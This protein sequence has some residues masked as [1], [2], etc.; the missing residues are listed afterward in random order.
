MLII[1]EENFYNY[2]LNKPHETLII[3][4]II[5]HT[6]NKIIYIIIISFSIS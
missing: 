2:V 4:V 3:N 6:R 1:T 5:V